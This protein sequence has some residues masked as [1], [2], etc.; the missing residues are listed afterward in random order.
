MFAVA[1][2]ALINMLM[3][4][5]LLYGLADQGVLPHVARHG[6]SD[7]PHAVGRD[8]LHHRHR[9]RPHLL[10]GD[11]QPG[12]GDRAPRRHHR[13]PAPLRLHRRQHRAHRAAPPPA[14]RP[15]RTSA[16]RRFLP[17]IGAA[18]C[19]YLA[20]PWARSTAQMPQY[21]I[22]A[23]LLAIGVLLWAL[24][25]AWNRAVRHRADPLAP[26]G[27]ARRASGRRADQLRPLDPRRRLRHNGREREPARMPMGLQELP[28]EG[29]HLVERP[30]L[31]HPALHLAPRPARGRGRRGQRLLPERRRQ[32]R[33]G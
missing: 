32:P 18:T 29:L 3:A 19:A 11:E 25:W 26:P 13:A 20:G 31:R 9:L 14:G 23:W 21:R 1:N 15:R 17:W 12:A 27:G 22:A 5:R 10:R 8:P 30:D 6:A 33:A 4:S 28:G 16:R 7:A 2:S 24:T